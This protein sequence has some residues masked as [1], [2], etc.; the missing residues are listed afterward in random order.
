[1]PVWLILKRQLTETDLNMTQMLEF[2]D[3]DFKAVV[4]HNY[5]PKYIEKYVHNK[6]SDTSTKKKKLK[7]KNQGENSK[8]EK[9]LK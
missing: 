6:E 5:A 8:T 9:Y 3:K 4:S 7:E 2:A 1:M